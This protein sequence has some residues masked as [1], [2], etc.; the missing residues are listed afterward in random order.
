MQALGTILLLA[1]GV[2]FLATLRNLYAPGDLFNV[3]LGRIATVFFAGA[4]ALCFWTHLQI[5]RSWG[6]VYYALPTEPPGI[7]DISIRK[8]GISRGWRGRLVMKQDRRA[9][10]PPLSKFQGCQWRLSLAEGAALEGRARYSEDDLFET[11]VDG[12]RLVLRYEVTSETRPLLDAVDLE[13]TCGYRYR[14]DLAFGYYIMNLFLWASLCALLVSA[15]GVVLQRRRLAR[16]RV[17][18]PPEVP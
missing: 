1:A 8:L 18:A 14:S 3:R 10:A 13:I 16:Y 5:G 2:L 4:A 15:L 11:D 12:D 9:A 6:P 17:A 7:H